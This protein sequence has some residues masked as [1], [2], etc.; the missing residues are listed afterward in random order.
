M[1]SRQSGI[2]LIGFLIVLL[3]LGFFAFMGMKLVPAYIEF[4]GV[5]KAMSQIATSGSNQDLDGIRRDLM[6]KMG[7]QY[8]DDATI[9]PKDITLDRAN[10]GARLNVSYEKQIHFLYNID[11]LLHFDNSVQLRNAPM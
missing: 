11:F 6:F 7:F 8:V 3:V 4:F 5:K 1:K 2:T 9:Q 10:N